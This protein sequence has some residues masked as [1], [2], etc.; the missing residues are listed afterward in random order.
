MNQGEKQNEYA[1]Q[2]EKAIITVET[3]GIGQVIVE[4]TVLNWS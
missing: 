1:A 4:I 3:R 2:G